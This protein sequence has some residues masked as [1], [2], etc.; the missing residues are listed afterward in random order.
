MKPGSASSLTPATMRARRRS[1]AGAWVTT[2][3]SASSGLDAGPL[4]SPS[5]FGQRQCGR[6]MHV[7][8]G[9][10]RG[11]GSKPD[12]CPFGKGG[13]G[14]HAFGQDLKEGHR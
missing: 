13:S 8:V 10:C 4:A 3:N 12:G 1:A 11:D 9:G 6:P 2:G 5:R 14:P 7:R